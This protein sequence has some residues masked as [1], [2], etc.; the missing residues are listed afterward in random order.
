VIRLA[1]SPA[2]YK[3][4]K[5]TLPKGAKRNVEGSYLVHLDQLVVDAMSCL[6]RQGESYSDVILRLAAKD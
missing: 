1:I 2:A 3:A 6:R 4:I 5:S